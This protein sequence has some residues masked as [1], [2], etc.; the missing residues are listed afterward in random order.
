MCAG[1]PS[2]SRLLLKMVQWRDVQCAWFRSAK[3][4][5]AEG[6]S[7][8]A[9][10]CPFGSFST[11][12]LIWLPSFR[13]IYLRSLSTLEGS[14]LKRLT[15]YPLGAGKIVRVYLGGICV[16]ST[17]N[18]L[19]WLPCWS[20]GVCWKSVI[21]PSFFLRMVDGVMDSVHDFY[22]LAELVP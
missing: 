22:L 21:E 20:D 14:V 16:K 10:S 5:G 18:V 3:R 17:C 1:S 11:C 8:G 15:P 6:S 12:N 2:L 19:R 7:L 4:I 13:I 9:Y